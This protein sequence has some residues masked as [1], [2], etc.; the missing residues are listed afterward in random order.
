MT[1]KSLTYFSFPISTSS[2]ISNIEIFQSTAECNQSG[3]LVK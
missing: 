1:L 3:L 2:S